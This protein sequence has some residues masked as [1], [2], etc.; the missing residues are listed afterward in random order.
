MNADERQ[1]LGDNGRRFYDSKFSL[2]AGTKRFESAFKEDHKPE[3]ERD[4]FVD[5]R[6]RPSSS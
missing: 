1:V 2:T 3:C 6:Y 5:G 4:S